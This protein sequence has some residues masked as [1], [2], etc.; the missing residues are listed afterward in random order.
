MQPGSRPGW[1]GWSWQRLRALR[2]GLRDL[3]P[4]GTRAGRRVRWLRDG[5]CACVPGAWRRALAAV[6]LRSTEK[7]FAAAVD[8][9]RQAYPDTRTVVVILSGVEWD[10][11]LFQRPQQL[12]RALARLGALAF[13]AQPP[14]ARGDGVVEYE[15]RLYHCCVPPGSFGVLQN[16][17]VF[18]SAWTARDLAHFTQPRVV[19][20]YID[21]LDVFPGNPALLRAVHEHWV[22]Q[23]ALV[24]ATARPLHEQLAG[25][26]P[27]ALLVPNAA[28]YEH[29][30]TA[31]TLGLSPPPE[32]APLLGRDR[33]L[34]VYQGALARWVDYDLLDAVAGRRPGYDFVLIGPDYDGSSVGHPLLCRPNVHKLGVV[35]YARLPR[36]LAHC[37]VGLVPF[38]LNRVTHSASPIKLFEYLAAGLPVVITPMEESLRCQGVLCGRDAA[39]FSAR[40]DEA[41]EM[42]RDPRALERLDAVARDNTWQARAT[43]LLHAI[44]HLE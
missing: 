5:L 33:P 18:V 44:E 15:P 39:E 32:L 42:T 41:L 37:D 6:L 40:V 7:H 34:M 4:Q 22:K 25:V 35:P 11:P 10:A 27:D 12:A 24:T 31:R 29:F 14:S 26:R 21:E 30:R 20:E 9:A 36:W 17:V 8:G 1:A 13:Y 3:A 2:R 43:Q 28:D 38:K 23:A 19:Y 16:P